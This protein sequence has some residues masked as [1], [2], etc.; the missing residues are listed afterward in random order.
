ML[1]NRV[2][3]RRGEPSSYRPC[4]PVPVAAWRC[5]LGGGGGSAELP[6]CAGD[7]DCAGEWADLGADGHGDAG[8]PRGSGP[9]PLRRGGAGAPLHEALGVAQAGGCWSPAGVSRGF[10]VTGVVAAVLAGT[11]LAS[12]VGTAHRGA[13]GHSGDGALEENGR[14]NMKAFAG[15]FS[16][17][18]SAAALPSL[19][20]SAGLPPS[21]SDEEVERAEA[22]AFLRAAEGGARRAGLHVSDATSAAIADAQRTLGIFTMKSSTEGSLSGSV[23]CAPVAATCGGG[24]P[25]CC[26]GTRCDEK[27]GGRCALRLPAP[28]PQ[29]LAGNSSN[30]SSNSSNGTLTAWAN[31][32]NGTLTAWGAASAAAA[33]PAADWQCAESG[34]SCLDSRCCR[35]P[36]HTCFRQHEWWASCNATCSKNS[37][38]DVGQQAWVSVEASGL[39]WSCEV[40]TASNPS[41]IMRDPRP[42]N[43]AGP[44]EQ[45]ASSKCCRDSGSRCF[46]KDKYWA[47]CNTTCNPHRRWDGG[48][49]A[50]VDS[51]KKEWE[52]EEVLLTAENESGSSTFARS[53]DED[54]TAYYLK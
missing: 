4:G 54:D 24:G 6:P 16:G 14:L 39:S 38:W 20:K 26:P 32:S 21:S 2:L 28:V 49:W 40:L 46:R 19:R 50:W 18:M 10:K 51:D 25:K 36:G 34:Q 43:C 9:A 47:S 5:H 29:D 35:H 37:T 30:S 11:A 44:G 23:S 22:A 52:C 1:S 12:A 3:T 41:R 8:S 15:E 48:A 53:E 17:R 7:A 27:H 42:G 45:C 13:Q 33:E 31:S